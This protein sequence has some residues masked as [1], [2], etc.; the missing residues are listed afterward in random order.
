M[1]FPGDQHRRHD[2]DLWQPHA[3]SALPTHLRAARW[4]RRHFVGSVCGGRP[5]VGWRNVD[6]A[7]ERVQDGPGEDRG[8]DDGAATLHGHAV[9]RRAGPGA[10]GASAVGGREDA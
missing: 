9:G 1:P 6:D 4:T 8:G 10:L 5:G 7:P 3:R 2:R